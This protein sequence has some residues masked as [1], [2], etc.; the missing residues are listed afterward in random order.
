[1]ND[2]KNPYDTESCDLVGQLVA[3]DDEC[4]NTWLGTVTAYDHNAI[5]KNSQPG[6]PLFNK[7]G[8]PFT[9]VWTD[10]YSDRYTKD[11]VID[12]VS[13]YQAYTKQYD[14]ANGTENDK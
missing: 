11:E 3:F 9:I 4:G 5:H 14:A 6:F 12:L 2:H 8:P 13:D 7:D 10:G 1:M